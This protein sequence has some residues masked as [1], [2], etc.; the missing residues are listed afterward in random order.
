LKAFISR[1]TFHRFSWKA[2]FRLRLWKQNISLRFRNRGLFV[3]G[4]QQQFLGAFDSTE[5]CRVKLLAVN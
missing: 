2:D 5:I 4:A 1:W 3:L